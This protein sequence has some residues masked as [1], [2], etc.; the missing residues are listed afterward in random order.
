MKTDELIAALAADT[1]PRTSVRQRLVRS[2]PLAF[3]LSLGVFGLFVGSRPDLVEALASWAL[4]KT[5]L[6]LG[7]A[8]LAAALA[9]GLTRPEA[10]PRARAGA[11]TVF[12]AGLLA[13]FLLALFSVGPAGLVTALADPRLLT[14]LTTVPVLALPLLGAV[15]WTLAAGAP[16]RPARTGAIGGL[17]AGGLAAALYSLHCDQDSVLFYIP[18]YGM[19]MVLVAGVG[20]W[21]G[22]RTLRW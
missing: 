17:A 4:A 21:L 12:A 2:L 13:A 16:L 9:L 6:P 5:L 8:I 20:H 19:A 10:Q 1:I 22:A 14:C 11:L 18:A 3:G 15:L 7:L